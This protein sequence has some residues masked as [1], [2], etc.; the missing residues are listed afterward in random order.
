MSIR[1]RILNKFRSIYN[2]LLAKDI[3]HG[4]YMYNKYNAINSEYLR[5]KVF[6]KKIFL[7]GYPFFIREI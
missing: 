2:T 1:N 5:K 7:K 3:N 4:P 6:L